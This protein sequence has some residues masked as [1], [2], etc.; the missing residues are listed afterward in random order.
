MKII[1]TLASI[2]LLSLN[3]L[4]IQSANLEKAKLLS[5]NRDSTTINEKEIKDLLLKD[6]IAEKEKRYDELLKIRI[7][8]LELAEDEYGPSEE[9]IAYL[10][11]GIARVYRL[12]GLYKK[13][14]FHYKKAI[15]ILNNIYGA[16]HIQL[17]SAINSL[18]LILFDQGLFSDAEFQYKESLRI[19][20]KFYGGESPK[21]VNT[22]SN[23]GLTYRELYLLDNAEMIYL[24]CLDIL[25]KA[26]IFKGK[27]VSQVLLNL[28]AVYYDK[29]HTPGKEDQYLSLA[30]SY[31]KKALEIDMELYGENNLATVNTLENLAVL[32]IKTNRVDLAES[33]LLKTLEVRENLLNSSH[34][35]LSRTYNNLG[36]VY[37]AKNQVDKS[38]AM[39]KKSLDIAQKT[40]G[41]NHIFTANSRSNLATFYL[42]N[43]SLQKSTDLFRR[44]VINISTIIQKEAP[45]MPLDKRPVFI[46]RFSHNFDIIYSFTTKGKLPPSLALY[47]RLNRQGILQDIERNQAMLI[48]GE[49]QKILIQLNETIKLISSLQ[50]D[51]KEWTEA[52]VLKEKLEQKL[53]R[54]IPGYSPRTVEVMEVANV[55]PRDSLLIEFQAY[56]DLIE[57]KNG[58]EVPLEKGYLVILLKPN[59]DVSAIDLGK[60]D[61]IDAKIKKAILTT[62]E[63]LNDADRQW[64]ELS[65]LILD[66]IAKELEGVETVFISPD[67]ELNLIPFAALTTPKTNKYLSEVYNLRLLTTGR[68]L[69]DLMS[70]SN[71]SETESLVIANPDFT[72]ELEPSSQLVAGEIRLR[73]KKLSSRR[74]GEL[75][76]TENE[77]L[78]V[79]KIINGK[80]LMQKEATEDTVKRK[81]SPKVLHIASHSFY[82]NSQ[83]SDEHPLIRSGIVLAGANQVDTKSDDDGLLTALEVSKINWQGTEIV[84]ISGCESGKGEIFSGEGVYGLKRAI[85]VAGARA[86]LLSLWKVNDN[87]TADFM[88]SFY[89]RLREGKGRAKALAET[90]K[91]FRNH[92]NPAY[93]LPYVWAAFQLSG[94]WRPIDW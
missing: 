44:N 63:Y 2:S 26:K 53:Y 13:A 86:N 72:F 9:I 10:N 87:A 62:N 78:A 25:Q 49:S 18:G 4:S 33:Y 20:E 38:E 79:S 81:K 30:E 80:L 46:Q 15:S 43:N 23:L 89:I 28:G 64:K 83:E 32:Y 45:L 75:P 69:L 24:R 47:A 94:D 68:E 52:Y 48:K 22:L 35:L 27:E 76:Y 21:L 36:L 42:E 54:S 29:R 37:E 74:W 3:G 12:K 39:Y 77:G 59:G 91:E 71:T 92:S 70:K 56:Y 34:P 14:E 41:E 90:Q 11:L 8:L 65:K 6:E 57:D 67:S 19:K 40:Y 82:L 7:R 55:M 5:F 73:S 16:N 61:V 58:I 1:I 17:G 66:P 31:M 50:K 93:R 51:S 88:E 60:A 85:T 84:V